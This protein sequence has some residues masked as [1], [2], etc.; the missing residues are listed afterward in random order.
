M[1]SGGAV[2]FRIGTW[3]FVMQ[4]R[5]SCKRLLLLKGI[6][7]TEPRANVSIEAGVLVLVAENHGFE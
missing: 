1:A 2:R 6:S 5:H 4:G 7:T 3:G